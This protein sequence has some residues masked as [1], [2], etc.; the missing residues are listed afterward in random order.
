MQSVGLNELQGL[1]AAEPNRAAS[2][3]GL[4]VGGNRAG[5]GLRSVPGTWLVPPQMPGTICTVPAAEP[6]CENA[7]IA[8]RRFFFHSKTRREHRASLQPSAH[9]PLQVYI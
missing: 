6:A 1:T 8:T 5:A 3:G 4:G 9:K 2:C 7:G